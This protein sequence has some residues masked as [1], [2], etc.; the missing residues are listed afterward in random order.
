MEMVESDREMKREYRV[1]S[2][3][4]DSLWEK[5]NTDVAEG[6]QKAAQKLMNRMVVGVGS[7]LQQGT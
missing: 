3:A 5:M 4:G 1:I 6:K 7:F 2:S